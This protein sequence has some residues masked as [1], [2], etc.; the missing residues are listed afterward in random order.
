MPMSTK[1]IGTEDSA[2]GYFKFKGATRDDEAEDPLLIEMRQTKNLASHSNGTGTSFV[3]D[4]ATS[5]SSVSTT[6]S[7]PTS[8]NAAGAPT[9]SNE[10]TSAAI[11][12][13]F[14]YTFCSITMVLTNK[15]LASQYDADIDFLVIAFQSLCAVLLVLSCDT[16]GFIQ[17]GSAK[18]DPSVALQWLPVNLFF[19]SMLSTGFLSLRYLN[20]PMVT[21]FKN[22]TNVGIMWGE[23]SLYG[24]HVSLG[25]ILAC[26][27]MILGAVL[28]AANDITFSGIGYFWMLSNCVCCAGYVL[29]MKHAT[30]TVRLPKF[31]MVFYN[32]LLSLPI[33]LAGAA[34]RGEYTTFLWSEDLHTAAYVSLSLYAGL[35]G[36]ALNLATLWC[37]SNNSATTY[38]VVGAMNKIPLAVVGW[39]LFRTPITQKALIFLSLS[40]CGGFL[41]TYTK[42]RE[43]NQAAGLPR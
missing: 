6:S 17:H 14:A 9:S 22:L 5:S 16:L 31:A 34:V 21:I 23:W 28:A 12:S 37:V 10:S 30:K 43:A 4:A 29:Y 39:L 32:N 1:G 19:V 36:F 38:S 3:A 26:A 2:I 15:A 24:A 11:I 13:C 27:I 8:L 25:A 40:M 33:L 35:V 20:V 41:Y 18:F 7:T 42:L